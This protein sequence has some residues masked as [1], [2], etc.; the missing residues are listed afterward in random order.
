MTRL[1]PMAS[2]AWLAGQPNVAA[3]AKRAAGV[4]GDIDHFGAMNFLQGLLAVLRDS[5]HAG[6]LIVLDEVETIQR[7]RGDVRDKSLNAI[8]Q[9]IDEVDSGR[10]PGLYLLITGTPA[11]YRGATR[12]SAAGTSGSAAPRRFSNRCPFRQSPGSA[13]PVAGV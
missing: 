12:R 1:R 10:F 3:A 4:K 5:G 7:V 9:L 2:L 11:F 8:R 13:D 6:M